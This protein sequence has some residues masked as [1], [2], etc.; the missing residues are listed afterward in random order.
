[1]LT[2]PDDP[3]LDVPLE[4]FRFPEIPFVPALGDCIMILPDE[5]A[6]LEPELTITLPPVAVTTV[7]TLPADIDMS[8][9]LPALDVSP[10]LKI[11]LPLRPPVAPPDAITTE[12]E[13]PE[14][15]VPDENFNDPLVP[16][17][18]AFDVLNTID[19]LDF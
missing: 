16:A 5:R 1:M 18:P 8:P 2:E 12:P 11:M 6:L 19:P 4:N 9:P 14:L 17:V 15:V 3:Q 10:T 13:E 7:T